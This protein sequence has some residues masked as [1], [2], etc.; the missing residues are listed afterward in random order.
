VTLYFAAIC[1]TGTVLIWTLATCLWVFAVATFCMLFWL[2]QSLIVHCDNQIMLLFVAF[3]DMF[4]SIKC[5]SVGNC[6][7]WID[8]CNNLSLSVAGW[9]QGP[10]GHLFM[11]YFFS[12]LLWHE[13][14]LQPL[15]AVQFHRQ[16][17]FE[18]CLPNLIILYDGCWCSDATYVVIMGC[19][20]SKVSCYVLVLYLQHIVFLNRFWEPLCS[21]TLLLDWL[22]NL[23]KVY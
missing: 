17:N 10:L 23:C 20:V 21:R 3:C 14:L 19:L 13:L 1:C 15:R 5:N 2:L 8:A 22:V 18:K 16:N 4:S 7:F 11:V 9:S 12:F 6:N